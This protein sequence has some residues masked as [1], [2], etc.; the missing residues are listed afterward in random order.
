[1]TRISST[2]RPMLPALCRR[3]RVASLRGLHR[4]TGNGAAGTKDATV[5][6]LRS[7]RRAAARTVMVVNA[8]IVRHALDMPMPTFGARQL[9]FKTQRCVSC[10]CSS[11]SLIRLD[12]SLA[13][14]F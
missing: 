6:R 7:Q 5:S 2:D 3:C 12:L 1:M 11:G 8:G 13:L 9:A 14:A 4:R 10:H